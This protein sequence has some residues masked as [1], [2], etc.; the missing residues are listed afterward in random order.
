VLAA[1]AAAGRRAWRVIAVVDQV[2]TYNEAVE[3]RP[4]EMKWRLNCR[5]SRAVE[6]PCPKVCFSSVFL[7]DL[8][9]R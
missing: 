3:I 1:P 4:V 9:S 6:P 2:G 7:A 5:D 8:F